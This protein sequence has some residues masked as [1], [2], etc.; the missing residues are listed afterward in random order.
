M[1]DPL[2]QLELGLRLLLAAAFAA[3]MGLERQLGRQ[4]AGLRTHMLVSLGSAAFTIAGTYGVSGLGTVQDAGRVAA[5]V[6]TGIG[7]IG[8]GS[9]WRSGSE[10]VIRGLTTAASIWVAAAVGM[11]CGFGLYILGVICA[12]VGVAVL[13]IIRRLDHTRDL[14]AERALA[15]ESHN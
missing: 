4:P 13:H 7:F 11:L 14:A 15:A 12:L 3:V 9:I 2:L 10:R 6:V 1:A 8:A 5:Q